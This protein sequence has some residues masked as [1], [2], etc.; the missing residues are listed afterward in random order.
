MMIK[1]LEQNLYLDLGNIFSTINIP[2]WDLSN[3]ATRLGST[4]D[5]GRMGDNLGYGP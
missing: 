3:G 5:L 4:S 1:F 2:Y